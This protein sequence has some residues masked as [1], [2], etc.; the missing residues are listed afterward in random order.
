MGF[1]KYRFALIV[2]RVYCFPRLVD[3]GVF[4]SEFF[5]A[6]LKGRLK[7]RSSVIH[8]ETWVYKT[9][10][11]FPIVRRVFPTR[12]VGFAQEIVENRPMFGHFEVSRLVCS[13]PYR[14]LSRQVF[15]WP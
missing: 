2:K 15:Y 8:N 3:F 10:E 14:C 13:P 1:P 4:L 11:L 9:G 7:L 6:C 5:N 12:F